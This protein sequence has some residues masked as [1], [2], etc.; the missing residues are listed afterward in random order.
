MLRS[1]S[2]GCEKALHT[3]Y[4]AIDQLEIFICDECRQIFFDASD[5][6]EHIQLTG[7]DLIQAIS[8]L[9]WFL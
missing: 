4:L 1:M 8:I 7:H 9:R 5:K 3:K 2:I 6:V